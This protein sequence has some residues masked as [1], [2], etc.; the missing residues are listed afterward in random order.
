MSYPELFTIRQRFNRPQ[1]QNI[2]ET[3]RQGVNGIG[4]RLPLGA[5]IAI[6]V[7]S[8]GI[9]N[10]D[11]IVKAAVTCLRSAG[12]DPFIIPAMGSHGGATAEGQTKVL[13]GYGVT[14]ERMGAKIVSSMEVLELPASDLGNKVFIDRAAFR[15]DGIV[16]VNRIKPHTD[17]HAAYESG[18]VKM[19]VIGLGKHAAAA[20]LHSFGV[21]GLR[22]RIPLTFQKIVS[23]DKILFGLAVVENAYD[24]TAVIEAVAGEEI[25]TREPKLLEIARKNM[26][27]LPVEDIDV[28]IVDRIGKDISG[29][30]MDPNIIGRIR[31]GGQAEP[32]SPR[33]KNIVISELTPASHGN[34]IGIGL[35]DVITRKLFDTIDFETMYVNARASLFLERI[36]VPFI[37]ETDEAGFGLAL[38]ACGRLVGGMERIVR[39]RDSLRLGEVQV[40]KGILEEIRESVELERGPEPIFDERGDLLPWG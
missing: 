26:P 38:K 23:T 22:E 5:K 14:P 39:I 21:D 10:I 13:A 3:V 32:S 4:L 27:S 36:K 9:A 35:A 29:V 37:A 18:L 8:R 1:C 33:I 16:L 2:D 11:C 31:I 7:G 17:F 12:A 20:E 40:S 28:L 25:I 30:G 34:A 6:A 24:E 19:G 15:A